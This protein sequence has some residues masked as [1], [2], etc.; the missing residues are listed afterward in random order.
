MKK[1]L[2]VIALM[3]FSNNCFAKTLNVIL[4]DESGSMSVRK[5]ETEKA[6][7]GFLKDLRKNENNCVL[8]ARFDSVRFTIYERP[9]S[10]ERIKD[11]EDYAPGQGTP[12]NDSIVKTI[13]AAEK[14]EKDYSKVV[15]SVFTDGE[16]NDSREFDEDDVKKILKD[17]TNDDWKVNYFSIKIDNNDFES[18]NY[19]RRNFVDAV[20][21][22]GGNFVSSDSVLT[23]VSFLGEDIQK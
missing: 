1:I 7:N 8:L 11:I 16:E 22:S 15:F 3:V 5:T 6:L 12:L 19:G 14:F 21:T 17:K 13:R 20:H 2:F 4:L 18:Y 23:L 9:I 10:G